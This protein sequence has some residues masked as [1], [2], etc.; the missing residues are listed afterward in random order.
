MSTLTPANLEPPA[1]SLSHEPRQVIAGIIISFL[2]VRI[3]HGRV[4]QFIQD[5]RDHTAGIDGALGSV[6]Y[7]SGSGTLQ[8]PILDVVEF[9]CD[10]LKPRTLAWV[11]QNKRDLA[12]PKARRP[13]SGELPMR[14]C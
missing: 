9:V 10:T 7:I 8:Q 5:G 11:P 12:N 4:A 13:A 2:G 14:L 1:S 3:A 6:C